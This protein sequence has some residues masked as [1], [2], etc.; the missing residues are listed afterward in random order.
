MRGIDTFVTILSP[1]GEVLETFLLRDALARGPG[2]FEPRVRE[3]S[4]GVPPSDMLEAVGLERVGGGK[5]KIGIALEADD[6]VLTLRGQARIVILRPSSR[7]ALWNWGVEELTWPT[8]ARLLTDG[9]LLVVDSHPGAET[10]RVIEVDP[11]SGRVVWSYV[12]SDGA[13]FFA[14]TRGA[15]QR[16]SNG[17]TLIVNARAGEIVEVTPDGQVVWGYVAFAS[18]DGERAV[19][20]YAC[21][22]SAAVVER[23]GILAPT[24]QTSGVSPP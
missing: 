15:A 22:L 1:D 2:A 17:N 14:P 9:N 16:L 23:L 4:R 19:I 8:H 5:S 10:S 7:E 24:T 6:V 3:P 12:S 18:P 21:R 13:G 11:A 20:S